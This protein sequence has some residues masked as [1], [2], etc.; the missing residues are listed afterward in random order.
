MDSK[1]FKSRKKRETPNAPP[2][3]NSLKVLYHQ[4]KGNLA[5]LKSKTGTI[6]QKYLKKNI[7]KNNTKKA[8][9]L[10]AE[11]KYSSKKKS[12]NIGQQ[13]TPTTFLNSETTPPLPKKRRQQTLEPN[14]RK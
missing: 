1:T 6:F 12:P 4:K 10:N 2:L 7:R 3:T 9:R 14:P 5:H 8:K 13:T 11:Q